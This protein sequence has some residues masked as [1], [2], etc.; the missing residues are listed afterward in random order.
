LRPWNKSDGTLTT[1]IP[2]TRYGAV[3]YAED[4]KR[5]RRVY[6]VA[7]E[8]RDIVGVLRGTMEDKKD[9]KEG[10]EVRREEQGRGRKR[11]A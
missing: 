7:S 9:G 10:E 8:E 4:D 1:K 5:Y 3:F 2:G 11:K 6:H